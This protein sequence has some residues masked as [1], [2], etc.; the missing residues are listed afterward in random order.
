MSKRVKEVRSF[1]MEKKYLTDKISDL[2]VWRCRE[3]IS[4]A[5]GKELLPI[6]LWEDS[7]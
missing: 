4:E 1:H 5:Q 2:Q 7:T 3:I 6:A